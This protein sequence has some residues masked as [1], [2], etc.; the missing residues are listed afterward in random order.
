MLFHKP[1]KLRRKPGPK[2][3][4]RKDPTLTGGVLRKWNAEIRRRFEGL[5]KAIRTEIMDKDVLGLREGF[6]VLAND[7]LYLRPR[8]F[9]YTTDAE[10]L[11]GFMGW[12][13]EMVDRDVLEVTERVGPRVTGHEGW[14]NKYIRESYGKGIE[15]TRHE[16]SAVGLK[17]PD[18]G[19]GFELRAPVH[20]PKVASLY[21]RSFD[22]L[23]GITNTMSQ[24]IGRQMARGFAEGKGPM[25]IADMI[26]DRVDKIGLT[27]SRLLART[28]TA[29]AR[30]QGAMR[31]MEEQERIIDEEILVQWET[32]GDARV[33]DTH[34]QRRGRVFKKDEA[35]ELL[36]EPN[37]LI[38]GQVNIYTAQGWRP[39]R[40]IQVGDLV[41]TH[42][43]RF[44]KVTKVHQTP[45]QR[46]EIV[47]IQWQG[48]YQCQALSLTENHPV[49]VN[50]SW[51]QAKKIKEGDSVQYLAKPCRRC[52][53]PTAYFREYCSRSC[54]SKD[55]TDRQW[56][57]PEHQKNMSE[58]ATNQMHREYENGVRDPYKITKNA[59]RQVR[60]RCMQG[61]FALQRPE[62]IQKTVERNK[63][64]ES[65]K[66][67]SKKM[68]YLCNLPGY[69]E[70]LSKRVRGH[71][72]K[73]PEHHPLRQL[74]KK[75]GQN[76]NVSSL[77]F[78]F[79]EI[80]DCLG[81]AYIQQH[82]ILTYMVDFALPEHNLAIECDGKHWHSSPEQQASDQLRDSR[83][84]EE[85]W[86]VLRYSCDRINSDLT[87]IREELSR[88]LN[89]HEG[90]FQFMSVEVTKV[91]KWTARRGLTLWNLTV[92]EDESYVA[93]GFVVHNCRCNLM[94]YIKSLHGEIDRHTRLPL[95]KRQWPKDLV[96]DVGVETA[97]EV[98]QDLEQQ[99]RALEADMPD[100]SDIENSK[101][102]LD[103][104]VAEQGASSPEAIEAMAHLDRQQTQYFE[105]LKKAR[106][107]K[108]DWV[109]KLPETDYIRE[110]DAV[111]ERMLERSHFDP[112]AQSMRYERGG[113]VKEAL[114]W[115]PYDILD[116][117]D[118]QEVRFA[119]HDTTGRASA[120][121]NLITLYQGDG[122]RTISHEFAHVIESR[123]FNQIDLRANPTGRKAIGN[124]FGFQWMEGSGF[125]TQA[126]REELQNEFRS[127]VAKRVG[128]EGES[129]LD[130]YTMEQTWEQ[131]GRVVSAKEKYYAGN[132]IDYYEGRKY[133]GTGD[134][135]EWWAVNMERYSTYKNQLSLYEK[136]FRDSVVPSGLYSQFEKNA[137]ESSGWGA[138]QKMYPKLTTFITQ[139]FDD[140]IAGEH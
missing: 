85:G 98:L 40:D 100:W 132:F 128:P 6:L 72:L 25:D 104:L 43:G 109:S 107:I 79:K 117:A 57:D 46:P 23:K 52:G 111:V 118:Q 74:R 102:R 80:L 71:I 140:R 13:D 127:W 62:A 101:A 88:I 108:Y 20:A 95:D 114:D 31:E 11:E 106:R 133:A 68:K 53:R 139:T 115:V 32:A 5:K 17:M 15:S 54:N 96:E 9:K 137:L 123:V 21:S 64:E 87:G 119:F 42:K 16:L 116:M 134:G 37:C 122:A 105:N 77:E 125:A 138:A 73:H 135:V 126:K 103:A 76:H 75:M 50:G 70:A 94:P 93:K 30:N 56:A 130:T 83:I 82:P 129:V 22:E 36:G 19:V 59:Q 97:P 28:E 124:G 90:N 33:R 92:E 84:E 47:N 89:N 44:R 67:I 38:D 81:V 29:Y 61:V 4:P 120:S 78:K 24:Q 45:Q 63:S 10:K 51:L 8:E 14:Q 136:K 48:T 1:P 91:K 18:T 86:Q 113:R 131:A 49:L 7:T 66:N 110:R 65:R 99:W 12:L 112:L 2:R 34:A 27:R 35:E 58:K 3:K 41:L 121:G 60:W 39:I 55:I 26:N 69:K